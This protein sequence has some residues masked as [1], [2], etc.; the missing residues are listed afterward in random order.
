VSVFAGSEDGATLQTPLSG[1]T[2]LYK[3]SYALLVGVSQYTN[4]WDSLEQIP[5]ELEA[6]RQAL[7]EHG[8]EVTLELEKTSSSEIQDVYQNF[9]DQYGYD[10]NNRLL[11]IFSGHG[12][13]WE[14]G[15][16]GYLVPSDAPLPA[17][18]EGHPGAP[19]LRSVLHVSQMVE[20]SR[21]MTVRHAMFLFDSCFSGTVF[22]SRA[23]PNVRRFDLQN[24][25]QTVR[26][27]ITAGSASELVPARSV[28]MPAFVNAISNGAAD[29]YEDGYVTGTELGLFLQSEVSQH[30]AQTPQFG[31]HPSYHLAQGEFLFVVDTDR[32]RAV[33]LAGSALDQSEGNGQMASL[34][35]DPESTPQALIIDAP[36]FT[37]KPRMLTEP[38]DHLAPVRSAGFSGDE[39]HIITAT[40]DNQLHLWNAQ[41]GDH[42]SSVQLDSELAG[43]RK[44]PV[45]PLQVLAW[46]GDH[47]MLIWNPDSERPLDSVNRSQQR[48]TSADGGGVSISGNVSIDGNVSIAG[49]VSI[50][51]GVSIGEGVRIGAGV[52]V[53]TGASGKYFSD[54]SRLITRDSKGLIIRDA[55]TGKITASMSH[56]RLIGASMSQDE[57]RVVSWSRQMKVW[58]AVTGKPTGGNGLT[59]F[60]HR[61]RILGASFYSDNS[62]I[63]SWSEDG[64]VRL[65]DTHSGKLA[66]PLFPKN[67]TC[68]TAALANP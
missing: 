4:G 45:K 44:N 14:S 36:G 8:F 41:T 22:K 17:T 42:H 59:R 49:D 63:M 35:A 21:Q 66:V 47:Q 43:I 20:W 6:A 27:F 29:L 28:F 30:A 19:F 62:R 67:S 65:W 3:K 23:Q 48:R 24:A 37:G 39:S 57:T 25:S 26:Q 33:S 11:F 31:K 53:S 15:N 58:D 34:T 50:G 7:M 56:R 38:M 13:T 12:H 51:D 18:A 32:S 64:S 52:S 46:T 54:G 9:I 2:H 61:G 60:R 68:G 40:D 1:E 10:Q 5:Y 55:S 16:Q